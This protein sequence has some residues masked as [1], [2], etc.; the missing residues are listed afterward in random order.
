MTLKTNYLYNDNG[1]I[2]NADD[3]R[4][5][6]YFYWIDNGKPEGRADEF[7]L[8]AENHIKHVYFN[9]QFFAFVKFITTL[10]NL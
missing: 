3:T 5:L 10:R 9:L 2:P 7:W 1:W 4:K 8:F 6:A